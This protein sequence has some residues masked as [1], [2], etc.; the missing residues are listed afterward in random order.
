MH[1]L[2][3]IIFFIYILVMLGIGYYFHRKNRDL[4]DYYVGGRNM[5]SLHVGLS[6]VATDVGRGF[7]IGLG[8]LD[9]LMGLVLSDIIAR[10]MPLEMNQKKILTL[11]KVL[12]MAFGIRP[13]LYHHSPYKPQIN[14]ITS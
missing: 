5:S 12:T 6:V 4:E 1:L 8:G 11:S 3:L 2:D 14:I 13:Y 9:F 7:S 10:F